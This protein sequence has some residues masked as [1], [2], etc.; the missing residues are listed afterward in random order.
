MNHIIQTILVGVGA[1]VVMDIYSLTLNTFGI[2]TLDYRFLGRWIG[3]F[4]KGKFSHDK[5]F[6]ASPIKHELIL[7]WTAHYLIGITFAGLLVFVYGK[8][9]LVQPSLSPALIIGIVT[10]VA[11]FF[12]M[13]PAFGIGFA[14]SKVPDPIKARLMSLITHTIYGLGLF[15]SAKLLSTFLK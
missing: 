2:K 15:L 11:P 8:K 4:S 14:A 10:V 12:I 1:T 13:Q 7:G 5:I 3:Y 6:T 9:W